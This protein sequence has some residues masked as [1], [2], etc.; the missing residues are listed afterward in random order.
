MLSCSAG[1][2]LAIS[3]ST[4]PIHPTISC[5]FSLAI[6]TE[7]FPAFKALIAQA[8]AE[9][10]KEPGT[11][12]YEYSVNEAHNSAHILERYDA[13]VSQ[14]DTTS[15]PSPTASWRCAASPG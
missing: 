7:D 8:V 9:T 6:E 11:L 14:V 10:R 5:L 1:Y 2:V 13:V 4:N 3:R 12:V 15:C